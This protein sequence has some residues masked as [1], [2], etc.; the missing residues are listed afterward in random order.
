[1]LGFSHCNGRSNAAGS[2]AVRNAAPC[3]IALKVRASIRPI[4][5]VG[6]SKVVSR[7]QALL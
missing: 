5:K 6:K 2:A 3:R 4:P 1:M 7:H